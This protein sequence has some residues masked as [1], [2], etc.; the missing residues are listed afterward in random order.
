MLVIGFWNTLFKIIL[1]LY[2]V[3]SVYFSLCFF[4]I[5]KQGVPSAA[6]TAL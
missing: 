3:Y 2:H 6:L 1:R 5:A 4:S